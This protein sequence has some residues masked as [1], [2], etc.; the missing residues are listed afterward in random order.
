MDKIIIGKVQVI[1]HEKGDLLKLATAT[2]LGHP[3]AEA[4]VSHVNFGDFKGWKMHERQISNL[5][6]LSGAVRFHFETGQKPTTY[7]LEASNP[8]FIRI[9]TSVWFGFE[10]L[11]ANGSQILNLSSIEHDPSESKSR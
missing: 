8:S 6:V 4:Y 7:I 3:I 9:P 10:G 1:A 11:D 2:S 5:Y